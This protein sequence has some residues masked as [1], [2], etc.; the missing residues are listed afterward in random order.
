MAKPTDLPIWATDTNFASGPA[1]GLPTKVAPSS[2]ALAQGEV[3]GQPYRGPRHN[4]WMNLVYR[5]VQYV[6]ALPTESAFLS[7][8]FTWAGAH[9]FGAGITLTGVGNER[10]QHAALSDAV[11]INLALAAVSV[12]DSPGVTARWDLDTTNFRWNASGAGCKVLIPICL[13]ADNVLDS[14][15]VGIS[16]STTGVVVR[17]LRVTR[18]MTASFSA[19]TVT[20][21]GT[22]TSSAAPDEAV[23]VI[24]GSPETISKG[25]REH[26][27]EVTSAATL[28][29]LHWAR[30]GFTRHYVGG[31]AA[32]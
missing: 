30:A 26:F 7:A 18:D 11:M 6:D 17:V 22:T 19:P 3:P 4:W 2:G 10:I 32:C 24:L 16:S 20:V 12:P 14:V 8:A 23:T 21:L 13:Q 25:A 31:G 27:I 5:W 15:Q 29:V 1:A 28:D 9:V